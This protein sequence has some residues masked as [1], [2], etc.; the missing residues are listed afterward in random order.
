MY[1]YHKLRG[2]IVE[3]YGTNAEFAKAIG[4]TPVALSRKLNGK[5]GF[6]QDDIREWSSPEHLDIKPE[7][8][9]EYFFA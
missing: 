8:Y 6:S 9:P 1:S 7:E 3:K 4:I 2:R 5:T